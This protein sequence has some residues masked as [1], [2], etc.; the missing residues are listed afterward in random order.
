MKI[1]NK[2]NRLS[3][4]RIIVAVTLLSIIGLVVFVGIKTYKSPIQRKL[5]GSWNVELDNSYIKRNSLYEFVWAPVHIG[6]YSINLLQIR[7]P[8]SV[9]FQGRTLLDTT[10]VYD[11]E[12]IAKN[13]NRYNERRRKA[14][15]T[16]QVISRNPDSVFFNAPQS[17]LHGKYA[18]R[19]FI[20]RRGYRNMNNIY[21]VALT[22]DSTYL[23]F[24]KAG[25]VFEREVRNWESRN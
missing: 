7:E 24:N 16:W 21:K 3:K 11:E 15:G 22:N 8:R 9:D 23:I 18:V 25:F 12:T 10:I 5:V 19:F 13:I 14:A 2:S 4:N 1:Q 20:D 17:P 6:K